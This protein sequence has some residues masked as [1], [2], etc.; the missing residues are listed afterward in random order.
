MK[1]YHRAVISDKEIPDKKK[2]PTSIYLFL[3]DFI[4]Q[5]SVLHLKDT[6][7]V[8]SNKA[9]RVSKRK[10]YSQNVEKVGIRTTLG[11]KQLP[12]SRGNYS[13]RNAL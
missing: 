2:F 6:V 12:A 10:F 4:L 1:T 9:Y 7:E 13:G 3:S 5:P 8:N 11:G